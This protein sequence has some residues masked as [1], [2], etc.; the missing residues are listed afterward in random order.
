M[1]RLTAILGFAL[2]FV[3]FTGQASAVTFKFAF[4]GDLKSLDPYSLNE[5]FTH[6]VLGNVYEGLVKRDK[7]LKIIPGLAER[8]EILEPTRWR[9]YLRKGVKFHNEEDF[10]A[11]DVVFS[12]DR[13]RGPS[14]DVK[15][16]LPADAKVVKVD[17]YTLDFILSGPNPILN[18]EWDTWYILS[19]KWSEE[20]N[21]LTAQPQAGQQMNYAALHANGTGPFIIT[22]HQAGVRTIFKRNPNWWGKLESNFDEVIFTTISNDATRVAALLSGDVDWADPIP[23]QDVA[24]QCER[25]GNPAGPNYARIFSASINI[26]PS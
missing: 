3:L 15:T 10:T 2:A 4:Q 13:A 17:D 19:K 22:E 7:D 26:V 16:R 20:N 25:R 12:A 5:T 21:S 18:Y 24:R 14:S 9:F 23:L 6:G 8:W 11:D 1:K